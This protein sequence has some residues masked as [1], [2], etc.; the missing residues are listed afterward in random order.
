MSVRT[1]VVYAG[2]R[3][4]TYRYGMIKKIVFA[5]RFIAKLAV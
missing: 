1:G 5:L 4:V 2:C 3:C